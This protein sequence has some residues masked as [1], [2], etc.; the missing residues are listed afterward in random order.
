M[1]TELGYVLIFLLHLF[2]F[3]FIVYSSYKAIKNIIY[4]VQHREWILLII[5]ILLYAGFIILITYSLGLFN[6][7]MW[8]DEFNHV[9]IFFGCQ[10]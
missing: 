8:L 10:N 3:A 2:L 4:Y 5:T 1:N 9:K 7:N 6:Y